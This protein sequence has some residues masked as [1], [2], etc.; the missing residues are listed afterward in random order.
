MALW[1]LPT[2]TTHK[3]TLAMSNAQSYKGS[4]LYKRPVNR[5]GH[6]VSSSYSFSAAPLA[7]YLKDHIIVFSMYIALKEK[8]V[9]S[10]MSRSFTPSTLEAEFFLMLET[11]FGCVPVC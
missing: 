7:Y 6:L 2:R 5:P 10:I 4:L 3:N 11:E 9:S 1:R 8:A